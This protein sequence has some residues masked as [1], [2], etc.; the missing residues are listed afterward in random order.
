VCVEEHIREHV[1]E[2]VKEDQSQIVRDCVSEFHCGSASID[3]IFPKSRISLLIANTSQE[4]FPDRSAVVAI[5]PGSNITVLDV[6]GSNKSLAKLIPKM[7]T[8]LR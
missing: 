1:R 6:L 8:A 7:T 5:I 4:S 3:R 2:Y